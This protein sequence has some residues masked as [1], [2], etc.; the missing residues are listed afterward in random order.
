MSGRSIYVA[1]VV[2]GTY[3][4]ELQYCTLLYSSKNYNISSSKFMPHTR[5][6]FGRPRGSSTYCIWGQMN[7]ENIRSTRRDDVSYPG[8]TILYSMFFNE[9]SDHLSATCNIRRALW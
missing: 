2:S 3:G 1:T 9:A 7:S 5:A 8:S 4:V 6:F